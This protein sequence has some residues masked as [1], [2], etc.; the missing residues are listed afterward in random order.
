MIRVNFQDLIILVFPLRQATFA[1]ALLLLWLPYLATAQN[2]L[3]WT[4]NY[5]A[6]TGAALPEIRQSIRQS[7]PW[8]ERF[9]LDGMTDW[10][11][12]W[13]FSVA[14]TSS[15]CRCGSF[16]TQ[17][18]IATTL[19]RWIAPTNAPESVK[20]IWQNYAA[21]LGQHE[22]GHAAVA[23]AAA[24]EMRKRVGQAGEGSSCDGLKQRI[25]ELSQ[26]VVEEYRKRDKEYDE[27]TR[28]GATQGAA[29][30]GRGR[31]DR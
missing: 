5:Y 31:R 11:V 24:T 14:P 28:H 6:V 1:V 9:D 16:S 27:R 4:T 18:T 29:W 8:K 22:S 23:L 19:P 10:R 20:T 17:T 21:A 3:R 7:R 13:Q 30:P 25:N 2:S 26:Q 12:T 15:G